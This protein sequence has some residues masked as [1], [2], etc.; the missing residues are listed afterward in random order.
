M[1]HD[2]SQTKII[3]TL[4]PASSSKEVLEKM[5]L[6][7]VDV[8]RLNFSHGSH[9]THL[10]NIK[11]IRELNKEMDIHVAILAD[12]Q[13]PKLRIGE[14]EKDIVLKEG[15]E[16]KLIS[17]K[18]MGNE[19]EAYMSYEKLPMDVK[20]GEIILIDDGKIKLQV[21]SSNLIDSV[22][23]RVI[24]GGP[25]SSNKG[26][27]LPHTILNL[28][29]LTEKDKEDFQFVVEQKLDWVALSFVRRASDIRD[30]RK[31]VKESNS[32]MRIMAKIE[33]P[34]ALNEIDEIIKISDAIM[35]ARGDLG[36]EVDFD[37][38]PMIQKMIVNK[39][40][41]YSKPVII[42]TQ[43]MES[44]MSNFRPTRAEATDVANAVLDGAD[45]LMLSGETSVGKYPAEVINAMQR[46]IDWTEAHGLKYFRDHPPVH[47]SKTF[48]SD[49]VCYSAV[50]MAQQVNATAIITFT[51]SGYTAIEIS[52]YRP[53]SEIF[54]FTMNEA[55]LPMLSIVWGVKAYLSDEKKNVDD[56]V[57]HSI[58]YLKK[59]SLIA[60]G[61]VVIHVGSIPVLK[62]GK[63]NMMKVTYI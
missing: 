22:V 14:V 29:S 53:A 43:M 58:E 57:N 39:C 12:L 7:G 35:V 40:T 9:D 13:G 17:K 62:R 42:A 26:V 4:G 11:F 23:T 18:C 49:T 48:L 15:M 63:T 3:A 54:A 37:Q 33:K 55:L 2:K 32:S 60:E 1:R 19:E 41:D 6:E 36:V 52:S 50:K 31:L 44:M 8:C 47:T 24:H 5:F 51:N 21:V 38:V 25:L 45:T 59:K 27:N 30:L 46:I 34:E 16:F 28:P 56:Y 20:I 61:D 10:K